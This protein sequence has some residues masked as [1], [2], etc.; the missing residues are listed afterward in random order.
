MCLLRVWI[1]VR[2]RVTL[3][4][5][6]NP[7]LQACGDVELDAREGLHQR[8]E[9]L[10]RAA[11]AQRCAGVVQ[12]ADGLQRGAHRRRH[13]RHGRDRQWRQ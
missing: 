1:R 5:T 10:H 13:G 3:T 2:V 11:G 4:L 8:L 7:N 9:Q 12:S 6:L